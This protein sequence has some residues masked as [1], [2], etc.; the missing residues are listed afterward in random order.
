MVSVEPILSSSQANAVQRLTQNAANASKLSGQ[1]ASGKTVN[2]VVDNPSAYFQAAGLSNQASDTTGNQTQIGQ[3][4]SALQAAQNGSEAINQL[5]SQL[6]GIASVAQST[7]DPTQLNSLANQ[8]NQVAGQ[9]TA[10]AKDTSYQGQTLIGGTG[11]SLVTQTGP[12]SSNTLTVNS[13]DLTAQGLGVPTNVTAA[14]LGS[15]SFLTSLQT[16]LQTSQQTIQSAQANLGSNVGTL[17]VQQ[18]YSQLQSNTFAEGAAKLT[19]G[20]QT[21]VAAKTVATQTQGE[22]G[23][24]ALSITGQSQR[25]LVRLLGA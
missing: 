2:S 20:D 22:L 11:Q 3:S 9:I 12:S 19:Q 15:S 17:Q 21:E 23:L 14:N 7:T 5:N 16:S 24:Y 1:L 13:V 8:F 25:D 18:T 6:Q 4:I 10:I